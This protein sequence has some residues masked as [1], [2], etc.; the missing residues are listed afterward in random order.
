MTTNG[1]YFAR[2]A[3]ALRNAGLRRVS[4]SLDSLDPTNFKRMTGRDGLNEVLAAINLAREL[5]FQ[6]VKV[7]A[8]IIRDLN[9]HEIEDLAAFAQRDSFPSASLSSCR[10]IPVVPGFGISSCPVG[11]S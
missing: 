2:H 11:K 9:H 3:Q 4:F 7:N 10:S 1:F 6:P 5:G 8:V